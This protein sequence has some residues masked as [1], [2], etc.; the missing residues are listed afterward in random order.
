MFLT[1]ECDYAIRVVRVLADMEKKSA[2]T[3]GVRGHIPHPFAYKILKKLE[4]AGLVHSHRGALGGYQLAKKPDT[5]TLLEI[6]KIVDENLFLNECL[7][8][9]HTCPHNSAENYCSV[10]KEFERIQGILINALQE[11]TIDLLL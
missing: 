7:Q 11:K 2:K 3:I 1:K 8:P 9:E 5:I 4:R 10:H 6:I